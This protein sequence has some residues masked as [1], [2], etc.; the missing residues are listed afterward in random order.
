MKGFWLHPDVDVLAHQILPA[1]DFPLPGGLQWHELK[2]I[3]V[4]A[5]RTGEVV[6]VEVTIFNANLDQDGAQAKE[7]TAFLADVFTAARS[8]RIE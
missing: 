7:L 1:A 4:V 6:G 3:L 5:L 2:F 8:T